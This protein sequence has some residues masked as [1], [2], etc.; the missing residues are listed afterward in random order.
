MKLLFS[1]RTQEI[2]D[3]EERLKA[4]TLAYTI[5]LDEQIK[6]PAFVDGSKEYLGIV[7]MNNYL[8]QLNHE[9]EQWYY[10]DC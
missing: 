9:K 4:L 8:D 7:K 1:K 5:V 3:I 2:I 10:C 6:E